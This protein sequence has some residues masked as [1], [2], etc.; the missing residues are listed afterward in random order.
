MDDLPAYVELEDVPGDD[1]VERV[2]IYIEL[3]YKLYKREIALGSLEFRG[4]PV[5]C[6]FRPETLGKH[7]AFWHTM[8]EGPVEDERH[9]DLERCRRIRW[10]AWAIRNGDASDHVRVFPQERGREES[11]VLWLFEE[12]YV[13][14][15]WKR[16]D[17]Y[18]LKTAF[19]VKPHKRKE[20]ERDW[21]KHEDQKG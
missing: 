1:H 10:I 3:L 21:Q 15:L 8:Q 11:W 20:F 4:R 19:M 7:Y 17:C 18:L 13:V 6:Q 9:I 16:R 2:R 5:R 14:I 12:N